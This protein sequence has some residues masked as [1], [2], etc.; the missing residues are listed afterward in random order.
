MSWVGYKIAK[1]ICDGKSGSDVFD[2][3]P[4]DT[5][6]AAAAFVGAAAII[7]LAAFGIYRGLECIQ[8]YAHEP[9]PI[10]S[11]Q[12]TREMHETE[13]R[14]ADLRAMQ[15]SADGT[16]LLSKEEIPRWTLFPPG[17]GLACVYFN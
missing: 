5:D 1:N 13:I 4:D 3:T 17:A 15:K 2:M 14:G 11:P 10:S 8:N 12:E 6:L 7:G 9:P 16:L